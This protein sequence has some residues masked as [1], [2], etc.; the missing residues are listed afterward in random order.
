MVSLAAVKRAKFRVLLVVAL[1][2]AAGFAAWTW[3][4]PYAWSPDPA[5]RCEVVG[6]RV[7]RD[8]SFFWLDLHLK[9]ASGQNH[10]LSKPVRLLTPAG[11]ELEPADTTLGGHPDGG[12][13]DLW[14]KF[15]LEAADLENPLSLRI[16]DG[17]LVLKSNPGMPAL[18]RSDSEYFTTHHW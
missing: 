17:V 8:Q 10:D 7:K 1:V 13:T 3:F 18:G 14:Y 12:T 4:R 15:W 2:I 5:A 16:N 6:A 9:L 11:K